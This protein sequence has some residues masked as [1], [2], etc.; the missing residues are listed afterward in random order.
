M[1]QAE[2]DSESTINFVEFVGRQQ[3]MGLAQA[4]RVYRT[5]LFNQ[6]TSPFT[7]DFYFRPE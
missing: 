6:H 7:F 1:R 5:N 3:T 4:A 2:D